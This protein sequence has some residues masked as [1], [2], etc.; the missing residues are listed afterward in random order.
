MCLFHTM[1]ITNLARA[2]SHCN[3]LKQQL[4]MRSSTWYLSHLS[5]LFTM[6]S[7]SS[8]N[9]YFEFMRV[10][11]N[12]NTPQI[13][14]DAGLILLHTPTIQVLT[15]LPTQHFNKQYGTLDVDQMDYRGG[16]HYISIWHDT[17]FN[18]TLN[19]TFVMLPS[20][21]FP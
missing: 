7:K 17:L 11:I 16:L 8:Y 20:S 2:K 19:S 5:F 14:S 9:Y 6:T 4:P 12:Y 10:I 3:T 1:I 13:I 15:S 21:N 18:V